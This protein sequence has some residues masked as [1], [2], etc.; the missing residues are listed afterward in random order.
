MA[1]NAPNLGTLNSAPSPPHP[2]HATAQKHFPWGWLVVVAIV[3]AIATNLWFRPKK[4]PPRP[5]PPITISTTDAIQ[6]DIEVTVGALGTVTP[7][8]TAWIS[9]RVDGQVIRVNYTEGQMVTTNDV[10]AEIDPGP[11]QAQVDQAQGQ[12]ARDKALLEGA[13]V[14]LDRYNAAYL[15]KAIP[16]QQ[17]DDQLALVHQDE[18]AVKLDEGNLANAKVQLAYC[19]IHAPFNGRA[20]LRLIDPGN[21]VHAANTNA[22]V[23]IAQLQPI[24]VIFSV[25]AEFLPA[26]QR[27]LLAGNKMTVEAWNQ[28][29][30]QKLATGTFMTMDSLIDVA[31][32]TIRIRALFDNK[33]LMLFPNQFVNAKLIIDTLHNVTLVPTPALQRNPQ[34]AFVFVVSSNNEVRMQSVTPGVTEGDMTSVEGLEPGQ[35]I[36][37]NNFNKLGD[38]TKVNLREQGGQAQKGA[39]TGNRKQGQGKGKPEPQSP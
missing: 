37:T 3:A 1:E 28:D 11:Y 9:P 19:F 6:G 34:G 13:N 21:I 32:D 26:I 31:T 36:A 23:V 27:Q 39:G 14:D 16:K 20:G 24:T 17:V 30:T 22:L 33:D 15:K 12:L 4:A 38:G 35:L 2:P 25:D 10:L 29:I 8:Y 7:V 18:G 5:L